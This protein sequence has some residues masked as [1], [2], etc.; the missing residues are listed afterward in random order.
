MYGLCGPVTAVLGTY[1]FSMGITHGVAAGA[2]LDGAA[3]RRLMV[4]GL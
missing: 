1:I 4:M 3:E 2:G